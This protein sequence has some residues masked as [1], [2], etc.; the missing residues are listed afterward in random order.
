MGFFHGQVSTFQ[1]PHANADE[2]TTEQYSLINVH[3]HEA[4]HF[5][6]VQ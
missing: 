6:T 5:S 4:K 3:Y 2:L 1:V